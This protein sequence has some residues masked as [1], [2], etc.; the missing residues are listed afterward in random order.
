MSTAD[1]SRRPFR[2]LA[3][4]RQLMRLVG[5]LP[6]MA[7]HARTISTVM[8]RSKGLPPSE[9]QA[10]LD[11]ITV[12]YQRLFIAIAWRAFVLASPQLSSSEA[13]SHFLKY[14]E[15]S[16][17]KCSRST[18]Y[19]YLDSCRP[20]ALSDIYPGWAGGRSLKILPAE[21]ELLFHFFRH[22]RQPDGCP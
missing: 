19:R 12:G 7:S 13:T 16:G 22:V 8:A 15:R 3:A 11:R 17:F 1:E 18:L 10:I 9:V 20:S 14:L 5:L 6:L 2:S 21:R 4:P